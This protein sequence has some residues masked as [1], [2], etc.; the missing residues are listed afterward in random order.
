MPSWNMWRVAR[1]A[2]IVAFVVLVLPCATALVISVKRVDDQVAMAERNQV[3][4]IRMMLECA[5]WKD[6]AAGW[7]DS[8]QK[9]H[10]RHNAEVLATERE[11][12]RQ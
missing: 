3:D 11:V 2:A 9:L 7:K 12:W 10:R 1:D 8:V 6:S 5:A 4:T